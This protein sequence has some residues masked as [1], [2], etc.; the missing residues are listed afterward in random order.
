VSPTRVSRKLPFAVAGCAQSVASISSPPSRLRK[1]DAPQ[2]SVTGRGRHKKGQLVPIRDK[3]VQVPEFFGLASQITLLDLKFLESLN[4]SDALIYI[5]GGGAILKPISCTVCPLQYSCL[6]FHQPNLSS[7]RPKHNGHQY[8][9]RQFELG[10]QGGS[11]GREVYDPH[12]SDQAL[13]KG[14][15]MVRSPVHCYCYGG[16][17][18]IPSRQFLRLPTVHEKVWCSYARL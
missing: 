12:P 15:R 6:Y 2:V 18:S 1:V 11:S 16:L 10:G 7:V 5:K 9:G 8:E 13:S 4:L 17:R 3:D 14:N